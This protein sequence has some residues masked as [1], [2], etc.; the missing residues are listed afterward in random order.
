MEK[1]L[2]TIKSRLRKLDDLDTEAILREN[3]DAELAYMT[4]VIK[5]VISNGTANE[6]SPESMIYKDELEEFVYLLYN[7]SNLLYNVLPVKPI[8]SIKLFL[9]GQICQ[10]KKLFT[11]SHQLK[12]LIININFWKMFY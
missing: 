12:H 1:R 11:P 5:E 6:C 8:K 9:H 3:E 7:L 2:Q 10:N 4:N